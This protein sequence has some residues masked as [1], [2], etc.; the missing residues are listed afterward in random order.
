MLQ[1]HRYLFELLS[2]YGDSK[3]KY[4]QD[5]LYSVMDK[6]R[7]YPNLT[8]CYDDVNIQESTLKK[9]FQAVEDQYAAPYIILQKN[10]NSDFI[11]KLLKQDGFRAVEEWLSMKINLEN[12]PKK[13]NNQLR[14]IK[15]QNTGQLLEWINVAQISLFKNTL[16]KTSDFE[17]FISNNIVTL[18]IA[19]IHNQP[20]TTLLSVKQS[21]NIGLYMISTLDEFRGKG[22]ATEIILKVLHD[23]AEQGIRHCILEATRMGVNLYKNIGFH[24]VGKFVIYW[25]VGKQYI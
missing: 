16:F 5:G 13:D 25:K 21:N 22:Y 10:D 2:K 20:V 15:V 1:N 4:D 9:Y 12:L 23:A 17:Q 19:Y 18:W 6:N 8:L 24:E 14:I 7:A 3:K 11:E